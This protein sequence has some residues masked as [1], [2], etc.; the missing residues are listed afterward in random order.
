MHKGGLMT[1]LTTTTFL[2]S[3]VEPATTRLQE[4]PYKE[5]VETLLRTA[6]PNCRN[7]SVEACA[8]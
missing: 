2:V 1:K 7:R 4:V 5:A 8:R 3:D 6:A